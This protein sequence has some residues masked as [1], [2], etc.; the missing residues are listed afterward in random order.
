MKSRI[1]TYGVYTGRPMP[2]FTYG[3]G[4]RNVHSH[5]DVNALAAA[6]GFPAPARVIQVHGNK[7]VDTIEARREGCEADAIVVERGEA[8]AI[9]VA[10]C[11]PIILLNA[12]LGKA[13]AV[14]AGWRGTHAR[15][16]EAALDA[17]GDPGDVYAWIG[18]AIGSCCYRV[19]RDIAEKFTAEFPPGEWL[20]ERDD[21]PYLNLPA[22]NASLLRARGVSAID[23]EPQCTRDAADLHSF[24]RDGEQAGRMAAF[25]FVAP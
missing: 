25:V 8:A 14:H 20:L 1:D 13:A 23:V 10:D 11:V 15:I 12:R 24:R 4:D 19:G 2:G 3:L 21:G 6:A 17:L 5:D 22:L 18:P 16:A 7:V 9:R